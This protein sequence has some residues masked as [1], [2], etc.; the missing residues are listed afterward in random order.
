V[1]PEKLKNVDEH[2][3]S[4]IH[5]CTVALMYSIFQTFQFIVIWLSLPVSCE[6]FN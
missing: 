2:R 6:N 4:D 3:L 1:F 5:L